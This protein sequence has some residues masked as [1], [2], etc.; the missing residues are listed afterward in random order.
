MGVPSNRITF[1]LSKQKTNFMTQ[2]TIHLGASKAINFVN[3]L[4]LNNLQ[5][6]IHQS[7]HSTEA[8]PEYLIG[9]N[10]GNH[11]WH[12]F[13]VSYFV[14]SDSC[15]I[16]AHHTY[17]QNTGKAQKGLRHRLWME[18]VVVRKTGFQLY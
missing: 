7:E 1:T 3:T 4:K 5:Y 9:V 15:F 18:S 14:K 8:C 13:S 6:E 17:S 11:A 12:W 16:S 10:Y 2:V